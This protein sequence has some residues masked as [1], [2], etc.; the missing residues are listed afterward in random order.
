MLSW[1]RF[2]QEFDYFNIIGVNI[3]SKF[4][5][6][7]LENVYLELSQKTILGLEMQRNLRK[8]NGGE[9]PKSFIRTYPANIKYNKKI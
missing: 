9:I 6:S 5:G 7:E 8:E 1:N 2:K 3:L 4:S